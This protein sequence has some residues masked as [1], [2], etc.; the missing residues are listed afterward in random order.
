MVARIQNHVC[1]T[2]GETGIC[3]AVDTRWNC[4]AC[5]TARLVTRTLPD[6]LERLA[7]IAGYGLEETKGL[8]EALRRGVANAFWGEILQ[9]MADSI[10][11]KVATLSRLAAE[12]DG[13]TYAEDDKINKI[14]LTLFKEAQTI[15]IECDFP[16]LATAYAKDQKSMAEHYK[17]KLDW[18]DPYVERCKAYNWMPCKPRTFKAPTNQRWAVNYLRHECSSY[19][20][21]YRRLQAEARKVLE[22]DV[23]EDDLCVVCGRIHQIIKNR[24]QDSIAEAFADLAEAAIEQKV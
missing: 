21:A 8:A 16:D 3:Y 12:K 17:S 23:S 11:A 22:S 19:D 24:V 6:I 5:A 18:R 7:E 15:D 9:N 14:C 13:L 1:Y 10:D 2:C 4:G 20:I